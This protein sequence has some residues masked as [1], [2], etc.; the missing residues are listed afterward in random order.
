MTD[1]RT[2]AGGGPAFPAGAEGIRVII[3]VRAVGAALERLFGTLR[4]RRIPLDIVSV[5]RQG[6]DFVATLVGEEAP[7]P[8]VLRRWVAELEAIEDVVDV[9]VALPP[10]RI[11]PEPDR[12]H[13]NPGEKGI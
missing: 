13:S 12:D 4:R 5:G 9:W 1:S 7:G 10:D 6:T 2:C 11:G 8:P 3:R